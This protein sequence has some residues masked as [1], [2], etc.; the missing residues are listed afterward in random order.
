MLIVCGSST[1][2]ITDKIINSKGGLFNRITAEIA[3]LPFTLRECEQFY[4]D[5]G[6]VIDRYDQL[7]AYMVFGGIPYYMSL[8]RKGL[9]LAQN[10]DALCFSKHGQLRNEFDRLFNSL[11]VNPEANKSIIRQLYK[12]KEGM[13]RSEISEAANIS[14]GGG[15]SI[16]LRGLEES[17]FIVTYHNYKGY[18]RDLYYRLA[19]PF[20]LF[21][22]H[23]MES[24]ITTDESFWSTNLQTGS[25][26]A[27]HGLAFENTCFA[28]I[29]QIKEALG[30]SGV[31]TETAPWRS[32]QK[33]DGAQIDML[34]DR[35]DRVINVCEMKFSVDEFVI[36]KG[37]DRE[38]RHKMALFAEETGTKK[39]LHLTLVTTYG[40]KHNE[41]F[42]RVQKIVTMDD[43]F[44]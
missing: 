27:W 16:I 42:G 31:H 12:R 19:D 24:G 29:P 32:K 40:L 38:L 21:Y 25:L 26:N 7:Q 2:W 36:S 39:A 3:L 22:L 20:C 6:I 33:E 23:F 9:S 8:F 15:L 37:Y 5:N 41:Y 44:R 35:S 17:N 28:H 1:S 11:F 13:L 43:L 14:S 4:H 34:I 18:K 10:I 30:I